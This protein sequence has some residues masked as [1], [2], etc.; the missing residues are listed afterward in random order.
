MSSTPESIP[1][2]R[3]IQGGRVTLIAVSVLLAITAVVTLMALSNTK[4]AVPT[5][6]VR[7]SQA[8]VGSTPKTHSLGVHQAG[9]TVVNV[10]PSPAQQDITARN[11]LLLRRAHLPR[12]GPPVAAEQWRSREGSVRSAS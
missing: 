6:D 12:L 1:L 2:T 10:Q 11:L 4:T 3:R 8:T 5:R 7:T 9:R